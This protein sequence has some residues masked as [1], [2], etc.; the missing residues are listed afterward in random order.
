[1]TFAKFRLVVFAVLYLSWLA[2]LGYASSQ[3]GTVPLIS[4]AQ[5][6]ASTHLLVVELTA[7]PQ[8]TPSRSAR[9]VEALS[10]P[11]APEPGL[12]IDVID[13]P[14]ARIPLASSAFATQIPAGMYCLPLVRVGNTRYRLAGLPRSPGLEAN[15]PERPVIYPWT[16]SV[17][18]QLQ[19]LGIIP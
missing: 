13:L 9:V 10:G 1:M 18:S 2:W 7:D 5:L 16:D 19:S 17:R 6:L 3:R 12:M 11:D 8:G 4:R 14:A 15:F